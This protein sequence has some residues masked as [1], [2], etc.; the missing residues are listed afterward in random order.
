MNEILPALRATI[1]DAHQRLEEVVRIEH[2]VTD[3]TAYRQLL[4]IFLGFYRPLERHLAALPGWQENGVDFQARLKTPWLE[5]DLLDLGSTASDLVTLP[6]SNRLPSADTLA[7]GFGCLYVLEGATLGG[8]QITALMQDSLTPPTA[9]RF[10]ASYGAETGVRWRE[11]IAA[12]EAY[13][14]T[15]NDARRAEI[16]RG[17]RETF[18]CLH[19]WF[20]RECQRHEQQPG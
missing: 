17:A 20:V 19:D 14:A 1:G 7:G 12:L 15:A 3:P 13:A 10:F 18:A 5:S 9:R 11:F 16:V 4:E 6:D 2:R 8:R